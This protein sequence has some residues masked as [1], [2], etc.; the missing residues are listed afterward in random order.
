MKWIWV[1]LWGKKHGKQ[2][3]LVGLMVI[4]KILM[5]WGFFIYQ[6][7]RKLGH[8]LM[9]DWA[10]VLA[11]CFLLDKY[12]NYLEKMQSFLKKML[13]LCLNMTYNKHH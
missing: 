11:Y 10:V 1:S 2:H 13:D 4:T 3:C 6:E 12:L 8:R 7:K 5:S 9:M